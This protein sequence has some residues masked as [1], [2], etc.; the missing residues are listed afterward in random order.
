[1]F[2]PCESEMSLPTKTVEYKKNFDMYVFEMTIMSSE[3][4]EPI[5]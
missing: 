4:T 5:I 2:L 1:M 3:H